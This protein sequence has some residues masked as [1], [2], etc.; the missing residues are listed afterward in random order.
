MVGRLGAITMGKLTILMIGGVLAGA[1]AGIVL[2]FEGAG[3]LVLRGI[4]IVLA[5][6]VA[7]HVGGRFAELLSQPRGD[8]R[9]GR[10]VAA[11]AAALPVL[12]LLA[13][14]MATAAWL[15]S[16]G[17][18]DIARVAW[19]YLVV[20]A[21]PSVIALLRPTTLAG[22]RAYATH[23]AAFILLLVNASHGLSDW[24][25]GAMAALPLG[26]PLALGFLEA[27]SDPRLIAAVRT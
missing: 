21:P 20:V 5:M 27:R 2:A 6:L 3:D 15:L 18:R 9:V 24:I 8:R 17:S 11:F 16:E 13:G 1:C 26:M 4:G 14:M 10:A 25:G 12:L 7:L 22:I 19:C 23:L